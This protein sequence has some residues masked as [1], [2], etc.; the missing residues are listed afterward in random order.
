MTS[1]I[2][3]AGLVLAVVCTLALTADPTEGQSVARR[4]GGEGM[5]V[6]SF[7]PDGGVFPLI[8]KLSR[9]EDWADAKAQLIEKAQKGD[10]IQVIYHLE[11][12]RRHQDEKVQARLDSVLTSLEEAGL[13][14]LGEDDL[15]EQVSRLKKNLRKLSAGDAPEDVLGDVLIE[16]VRANGNAEKALHIMETGEV[17]K[18]PTASGGLMRRVSLGK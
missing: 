10:S 14:P 5:V 12:F 9:D 4:Q 3:I 7:G 17:P 15:K 11:K 8:F 1:K 13:Y 16:L 18:A 6:T 2:G